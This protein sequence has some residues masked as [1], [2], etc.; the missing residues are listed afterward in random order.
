MNVTKTTRAAAVVVLSCSLLG[1]SAVGPASATPQAEAMYLAAVKQAW[2][3]SPRADKIKTCQGYKANP[4]L[5]ITLSVAQIT[6]DPAVAK[7]LPK[8]G[9][10]RVITKYLAW[11][12]SGPGK[13]PRS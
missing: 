7:V 6:K 9:W 1:I 2:Q 5:M 11:A 13:T 8:A 3:T 10:K 12:C 4:S